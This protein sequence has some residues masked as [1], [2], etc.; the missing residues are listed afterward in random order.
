MSAYIKSYKLLNFQ[1]WNDTSAEITLETDMVNIIEGANE[2]GKSVLYKVLYNF[3]FPGYWSPS[4]LIR[5]GCNAG[6]LLLNLEDGSSIL[7]A[8]RTT[9]YTYILVE[10]NGDKKEWTNQGC[11]DEIINRL[12]LILD[13]ESQV[14]LNVIDSD[15]ALPFIKTS[16]KFNASLIRSIVEPE[17]MT[18]F[19]ENL[20][21]TTIR[22]EN[23]R[24]YFANK[25]STLWTQI[26]NIPVIDPIYMQ[27]KKADVDSCITMAESI[28][29]LQPLCES[30]FGEL[31]TIITDVRNP[32]EYGKL[33]DVLDAIKLIIKNAELLAQLSAIDIQEITS[34][35]KIDPLM[36][37]FDSLNVVITSGATLHSIQTT[38]PVEVVLPDITALFNILEQLNVFDNALSELSNLHSS[39]PNQVNCP[40]LDTLFITHD[41]IITIVNTLET[42]QYS[43]TKLADINASMQLLNAEIIKIA[44]EV[45]VCPTC[46]QLL[47]G[48]LV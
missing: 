34:P 39:E 7:Y 15:I 21:D 11:P 32:A 28:N 20:A 23:A 2:T 42:L 46:G 12:G 17:G 16:P 25:A 6:V 14:I 19:F 30:L 36:T 29:T 10:A 24:G 43:V 41:S 3:C 35:D 47:R 31:T 33:I 9:S 44:D 38:S 40:N 1:S 4:E 5:R 27:N 26:S 37:V 22:I 8:L 13:R 48:D 18:K 45:G